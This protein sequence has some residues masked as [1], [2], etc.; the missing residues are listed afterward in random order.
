MIEKTVFQVL[1]RVRRRD[2]QIPT[3]SWSACRPVA[4]FHAVVADDGDRADIGGSGESDQLLSGFRNGTSPPTALRA[5]GLRPC[6]NPGGTVTRMIRPCIPERSGRQPAFRDLSCEAT[7]FPSHLGAHSFATVSLVPPDDE[8]RQARG[9][10]RAFPLVGNSATAGLVASLSRHRTFFPQDPDRTSSLAG[11]WP[12]N[13]RPARLP[14]LRF[15]ENAPPVRPA[16]DDSRMV[17][18][19]VRDDQ[20]NADECPPTGGEPDRHR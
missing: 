15:R 4:D 1:D 9:L 14:A 16:I 7:T 3:T 13:H 17:P 2:S 11:P 19:R 12:A 20:R 10:E 6:S 5:A 8:L 18:R